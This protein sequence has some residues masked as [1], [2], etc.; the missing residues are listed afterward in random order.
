M[1]IE[2]E[3][4][5][6]PV[7]R[8]QVD[9]LGARLKENESPSPADI[10]LFLSYQRS[11]RSAL[12]E[13]IMAV[14]TIYAGLFPGRPFRANVAER[15]KRLDSVIAKLRRETTKLSQMQDVVGFRL[16][17]EN[18]VEQDLMLSALSAS[19]LWRTYDRR[20]AESATGYRAVHLVSRHAAGP[21]EFQLRTRMQHEWAQLSEFFDEFEPGV[22]YGREGPALRT[23]KILSERIRELEDLEVEAERDPEHGANVARLQKGMLEI[24]AGLRQEIEEQTK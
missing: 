22:K 17:V 20:A 7:S 19:S 6:P 14:G 13:T 23:L 4:R 12:E 16:T 9:K 11:L 18:M 3:Y 15:D 2:G 21:V 1:P 5:A 24:I 10:E 8:S